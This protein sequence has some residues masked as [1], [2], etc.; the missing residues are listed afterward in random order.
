MTVCDDNNDNNDNDGTKSP[1]HISIE[2]L[3]MY[4]VSN[5]YDENDGCCFFAID[6]IIT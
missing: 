6:I 3:C 1:I 4:S 5:N 2:Y